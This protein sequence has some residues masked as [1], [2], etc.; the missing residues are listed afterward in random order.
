[1]ISAKL[2][3]KLE[4]NQNNLKH[5]VHR[6]PHKYMEVEIENKGGVLDVAYGRKILESSTQQT[7]MF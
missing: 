5:T 2:S 1:M 3:E 4:K 7:S 6:L